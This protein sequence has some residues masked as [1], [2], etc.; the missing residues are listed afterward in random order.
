MAHLAGE[1]VLLLRDPAENIVE[2]SKAILQEQ[3]ERPPFL[4]GLTLPGFDLSEI[5]LVTASSPNNHCGFLFGLLLILMRP[6]GGFLVFNVP[7][8]RFY[9]F[10]AL[11][12]DDLHAPVLLSSFRIVR[13]GVAAGTGVAAGAAGAVAGPTAAAGGGSCLLQAASKEIATSIPNVVLKRIRLFI[14]IS[15]RANRHRKYLLATAAS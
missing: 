6:L 4:T 10:L 9:C 8:I 5:F 15:P 2:M 14:V 3:L 7:V 13:A 11:G 12:Y 1:N